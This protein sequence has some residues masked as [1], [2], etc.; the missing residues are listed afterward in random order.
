MMKIQFKTWTDHPLSDL[1][2]TLR[3]FVVVL[4]KCFFS[5]EEIHQNNW[6]F[7]WATLIQFQAGLSL[8]V[9]A[10]EGRVSW[11]AEGQLDGKSSPSRRRRRVRGKDRTCRFLCLVRKL[12]ISDL[13]LYTTNQ[14][15]SINWLILF[16][17]ISLYL[18]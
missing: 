4:S 5:L 1:L 10:Q 16:R 8:R 17:A 14:V 3:S 11:R 9:P 2:N 15:N 13:V 6:K 18:L 7:D 12:S